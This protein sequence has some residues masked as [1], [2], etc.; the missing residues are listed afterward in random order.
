MTVPVTVTDSHTSRMQLGAD[1]SK[2]LGATPAAASQEHRL[3]AAGVDS[4]C[5]ST[6]TSLTAATASIVMDLAHRAGA[7]AAAKRLDSRA[8]NTAVICYF[9][10]DL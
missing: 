5:S 10:S 1:K 4:F 8:F 3:H 2:T 6:L 9:R 7:A